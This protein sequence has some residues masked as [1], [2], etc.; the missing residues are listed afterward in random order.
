MRCGVGCP[1]N[2]TSKV[3]SS[4]IFRRVAVH[5]GVPFGINRPRSRAQVPV[6]Q[7]RVGFRVPDLHIRAASESG[8]EHSS[9]HIRG[10][11]LGKMEEERVMEIY[12]LV[13]QC[14][15]LSTTRWGLNG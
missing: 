2:G 13:I 4:Y 6:S 5:F 11:P 3:W 15:F 14:T 7:L 9:S 12:C 1:L 8:S 10:G